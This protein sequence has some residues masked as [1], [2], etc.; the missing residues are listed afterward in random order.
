MANHFGPRQHAALTGFVV[1][2]LGTGG[3]DDLPAQSA[4]KLIRHARTTEARIRKAGVAPWTLPTPSSA[5]APTAETLVGLLGSRTIPLSGSWSPA[6]RL[7]VE[8]LP[9]GSYTSGICSPNG[10]DGC[11]RNEATASIRGAYVVRGEM[12]TADQGF[13]NL[14]PDRFR[15]VEARK[16]Y[17]WRVERLPPDNPPSPTSRPPLRRLYVTVGEDDDLLF[18][19][20]PAQYRVRWMKRADR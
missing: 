2:L 19:E 13:V 16:A 12:F 11:S 6:F 18:F 7:V 10:G 5:T 17:R 14:Q 15:G 8:L 1:A 4:E 20:M 3:V 9:D